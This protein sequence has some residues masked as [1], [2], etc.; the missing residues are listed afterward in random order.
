MKKSGEVLLCAGIGFGILIFLLRKKFDLSEMEVADS[1][2]LSNRLI[3][4]FE[5]DEIKE[6]Y[7]KYYDYVKMGINPSDAFEMLVGEKND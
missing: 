1:V 2:Q 3:E 7:K 6:V 4:F 5:K